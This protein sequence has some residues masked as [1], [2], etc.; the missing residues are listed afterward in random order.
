ALLGGG[1]LVLLSFALVPS[2]PLDWIA[3][4][5][6]A[7]HHLPPL[8]VLPVG[9]LLLLALLRWREAR[10]RLLLLLACVPQIY[11]FYDALP[12]AL[13]AR[14]WRERLLL[15]L[16]SWVGLIGVGLNPWLLETRTPQGVRWG[17][18]AVLL[19]TYGPALLLVLGRPAP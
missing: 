12:L 19:A 1:L 3:N 15:V 7:S 11:W 4:L 6:R 14:S 13:I 18:I 17:E 2:W 10:G 9:P 8:L 16:C 5:R